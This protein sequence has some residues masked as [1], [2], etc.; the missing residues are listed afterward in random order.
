MTRKSA[1]VLNPSGNDLSASAEA[2][3]LTEDAPLTE[4]GRPHV[5]IFPRVFGGPARDRFD[6]TIRGRVIC[7]T[8]IDRVW[9]EADGLAV[10]STTF[11]GA[12]PG[13]PA[14]APD[15]SAAHQQPFQF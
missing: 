15:G 10:S 3:P 13:V 14:V 8:A 7:G 6:V 9:L 2:A 1:A 12:S 5:E 11:G 4:A